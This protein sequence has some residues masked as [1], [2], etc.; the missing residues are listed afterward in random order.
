M[1]LLPIPRKHFYV[2]DG[3]DVSRIRLQDLHSQTAKLRQI[4]AGSDVERRLAGHFGV[5]EAVSEA[6][7][8]AAVARGVDRRAQMR[9][10]QVLVADAAAAFLLGVFDRGSVVN[11]GLDVTL[12]DMT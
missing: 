4:C 6:A 2:S 11:L 10:F 12:Y 5:S 3:G 9:A 1:D 8:D 7:V